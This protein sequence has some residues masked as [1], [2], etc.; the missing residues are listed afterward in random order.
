MR[1]GY[2]PDMFGHVAQMPQ[3][4]RGQGSRPRRLAR[5][6]VGVDFHRFVWESPDGSSVVAEYLPGG[7][8]NAAHV[9]GPGRARGAL[10]AVVRLRRHPRHGRDRPHAA[11]ARP[12]PAAHVG[13][14]AEYLAA[15]RGRADDWRGEMRSAARATCCPA[16]SRRGST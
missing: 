13:T 5:R 9:A 8:G 4:L 16:S 12:A 1:V 11:R 14:L 2:L 3:I 6:A 15:T 7:Y 10:P